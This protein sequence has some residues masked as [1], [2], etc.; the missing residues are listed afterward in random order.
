M[1]QHPGPFFAYSNRDSSSWYHSR[2]PHNLTSLHQSISAPRATLK[3]YASQNVS[4]P[5][6]GI[7]FGQSA[8]MAAGGLINTVLW[9]LAQ[10]VSQIVR[11][12]SVAS[13]TDFI[14][15]LIFQSLQLAL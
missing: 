13:S 8:S 3:S 11:K 6:G 14:R 1:P 12:D 10:P 15:R 5:A 7:D 9:L 2:S 4:S